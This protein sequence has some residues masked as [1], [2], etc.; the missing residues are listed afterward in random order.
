V[1]EENKE[2]TLVDNT[3]LVA[4]E[5]KGLSILAS[6]GI[7]PQRVDI[8]DSSRKKMAGGV[9]RRI[10]ICGHAMDRHKNGQNVPILRS[11]DPSGYF[12]CKP[13]V[14]E[15]N[16]K[17][18]I[19]IIS[20]SDTRWFLK[21]TEG[22]GELHALT[23]GILALSKIEGHYIEWLIEPQCRL[24]GVVGGEHQIAPTLFTKEGIIKHSSESDGYDDFSCRKCRIAA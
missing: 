18:C 13:N 19:P 17:N 21:K 8:L 4:V 11:I 9:D 16:C 12:Q 23:R 10:C 6:M 14:M 24:C 3:E 7:D 20:V 22:S 1:T 5:N 15:C 2:L